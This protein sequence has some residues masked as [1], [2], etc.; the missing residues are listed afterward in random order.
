MLL[1]ERLEDRDVRHASGSGD[2]LEGV[3]RVASDTNRLP[4]LTVRGGTLRLRAGDAGERLHLPEQSFALLVEH[5][6][7]RLFAG[8][9]F[10]FALCEPRVVVAAG[11]LGVG[12]E[13]AD[14]AVGVGERVAVCAVCGHGRTVTEVTEIVKGC[15]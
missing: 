6:E 2:L 14:A 1:P 5:R 15:A 9:A 10:G 8:H 13:L 3:A 11:G 12:D 7:V 4:V